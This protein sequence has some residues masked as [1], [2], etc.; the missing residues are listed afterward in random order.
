MNAIK[1]LII[2]LFQKYYFYKVKNNATLTG[3]NHVFSKNTDIRLINGARKENLRIESDCKIH[4]KIILSGA[5]KVRFG[6]YSQLG[7]GSIVGALISVSIGD[8]TVIST[9][10]RIMDNNNHPINPL[11]RKKMQMS[12]HN[13]PERQWTY[14]ASAEICIEENVWIGENA[15]ICKGV[16]IGRNSIVA[17]NTVVTKDIPPNSI[18]AGN[19]GRIVKSNIDIT[20]IPVF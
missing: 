17:A 5:G 18:V 9:N 8:F 1:N 6:K 16:S 14:S 20:T 2:C 13:S 19:P 11:D 7:S 10:V 3:Q 12:P 15:R 4:G